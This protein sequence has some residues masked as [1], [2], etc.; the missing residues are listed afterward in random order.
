MFGSKQYYGLVAGLREYALEA[1]KKGFDAKSIVEEVRG[2]LSK[3]DARVLELFYGWYDIANIVSIRAGRSQFNE[4]GNFTR[5]QLGAELERPGDLPAW[6]AK[7]VDAYRDPE[8]ADY[9][10]VDTSQRFE[11]ALFEAY[12]AQCA[13]SKNRFMREWNRFDRN[14]RNVIAAYTARSKDMPA[15]DSLVGSDDIV[16][17]LTRS[18][19]ADWGLKGELDYVDNLLGALGDQANILEKER[20]IDLIRWDK[21]DELTEFDDFNTD[22]VLAYLAKVNIIQRWMSL[23]PETGRRMYEKLL[24]SMSADDKIRGRQS[25]PGDPN[26]GSGG[27]DT[28]STIL[29]NE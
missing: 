4:L 10:D 5:E 11:R 6:M 17:S 3:G 2:E 12:Y 22:V 28:D 9:E 25:V 29:H 8:N 26:D 13:R 16:L 20:T 7:V 15:V 18:S 23:D 27:T 19:A 14:L 1:D 24:A 21:A